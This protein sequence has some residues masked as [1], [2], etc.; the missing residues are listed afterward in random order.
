MEHQTVSPGG[1]YDASVTPDVGG[2]RR[3]V[4]FALKTDPMQ[5]DR[6]T[7]IKIFSVARPHMRAFHYSWLS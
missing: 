4:N 6:A 2:L 5:E 7:E 3:R 1:A